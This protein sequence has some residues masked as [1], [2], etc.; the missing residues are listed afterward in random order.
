MLLFVA[1]TLSYAAPA[2]ERISGRV[3][4]AS[5]AR[6]AGAAATRILAFRILFMSLGMWFTVGGLILQ[7]LIMKFSNTELQDWCSLCAFGVERTADD[8]Y[9]T[10]EE[11]NKQ[12]QEAFLAVGV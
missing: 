3:A 5:A 12:L 8:A 10:P 9:K 1:T 6:T 7:G 2:L 11:Q 4:L